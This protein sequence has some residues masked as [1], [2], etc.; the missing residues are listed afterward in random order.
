MNTS[1]KKNLVVTFLSTLFAATLPLATHATPVITATTGPFTNGN[2]ITI[3]GS[4]FGAGPTTLI[5]DDFE[6]GK[7]GTFLSAGAKA[8]VG[9]WSGTGSSPP[10]YTSQAQV[11]GNQAFQS[12][13]SQ[14][15]STYGLVSLPSKTTEIFYSWWMYLPEGDRYP[16]E[17]TTDNVNWK[18]MWVMGK[19][20][21]DDD[22]WSPVLL[23]DSANVSGNN[24]TLG[25]SI[26]L[27]YA[28]YTLPKGQWKR[29][30]TWIKA[31]PAQ[32]NNGAVQMWA[33]GT[34]GVIKAA[35]RNNTNVLKSGGYFERLQVNGY[36]RQTPNSRPTFDDVYVAVG[37]NARARVE[38]GDN[39][40]YFASKN[41][42]IST[43]SSW[44][45]S[46]I[47]FTFRQ[48]SFKNG[49]QAYLFVFDKNGDVNVNGYPLTVSGTSTSPTTGT[50]AVPQNFRILNSP[51]Q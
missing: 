39:P 28:A 27:P 42:A 15:W 23:K 45:D 34:D 37:P 44:N 29:F 17:G 8:T 12:D 26:W 32:S 33:L 31:D 5:F 25:G 41:L 20:P 21:Y 2:S 10:Y 16:G 51:T 14:S 49:Q 22:I 19:D 11:S 40:T 6:S 18:V 47:T 48:G 7:V 46:A 36:G 9:T 43:V 35:E 1:F 3:N 24:Q 30:S 38:I 50:V 13:Q 4:G